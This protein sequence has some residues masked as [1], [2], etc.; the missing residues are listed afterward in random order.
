MFKPFTL[1]DVKEYAVKM[2][3]SKEDVEIIDHED[4]YSVFFGNECTEFWEWEFED[5]DSVATDY[6]HEIVED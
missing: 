6:Y 4:Y 5:L 1:E 2:G 3:Y